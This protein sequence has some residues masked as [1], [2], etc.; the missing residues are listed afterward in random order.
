[1][2]GPFVVSPL[3]TVLCA[4]R[5]PLMTV[6]DTVLTELVAAIE[7]APGGLG[8]ARLVCVDGPAGSGKTT[9]AAQLGWSLNARVIHMDDLYPGW[10]GMEQGATLLREWV[11]EPLARGLPGRYQRYDWPLGTYAERHTVPLAD[12]LVVEGCNSAAL[13]TDEFSPFIIWVE[14]DDEMRLARGLDRDGVDATDQWTRWMVR[15]RELYTANR[16][17]DR[18]H[19]RLDGLGRLVG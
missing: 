5:S 1:M 15:E 7:A 16:T 18:A 14:A 12:V 17:T 13:T 8:G 19:V 9:L 11:L 4:E 2:T 6:S 10:D 3:I